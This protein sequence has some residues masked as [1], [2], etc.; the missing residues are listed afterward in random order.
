VFGLFGDAL[1]DLITD[2]VLNDAPE[3]VQDIFTIGQDIF[4]I[5]KRLELTGILKISKLTSDYHIQG[6]STFTGVV[7]TWKLGCDKNAP[8]YDQCGKMP[9][10][11]E[12]FN[13]NGDFPMDLV[14]GNWTGQVVDY[15]SLSISP[16]EIDLN[17]GKLILFVLQKIILKY[18]TGE[19]NLTD[20]AVAIVGCDGIAKSLDKWVDYDDTFK[21]CKGTVTLLES[22]LI[23]LAVPSVVSLK[24]SCTMVDENDDL[25]V[26]KLTDGVW[27]G[28][29]QINNATG[30]TFSGEWSAVRQTQP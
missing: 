12:Q 24:G 7:F 13:N 22:Y 17:Y 30:S 21:A 10:T 4:Q 23:G 5:V 25:V 28:Q 1:G 3:W 27:A 2:C 26:D 6:V 15:D 16:Y 29:V 14:G 20:A 9:F 18:L 11:M 19:D 8:D